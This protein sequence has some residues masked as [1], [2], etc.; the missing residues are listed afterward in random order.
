MWCA[1]YCRGDDLHVKQKFTEIAP[2]IQ[3]LN[4]FYDCV[5]HANFGSRIFKC[6]FL[7]FFKVALDEFSYLTPHLTLYCPY[8]YSFP[9]GIAL[10]KTRLTSP[11]GQQRDILFPSSANI[12]NIKQWTYSIYGL[13]VEQG[14]QRK[15]FY[16]QL[17]LSIV[18][19]SLLTNF[20]NIG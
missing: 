2:L 9:I 1:M 6:V 5:T 12:I 17:L 11:L 8:L 18:Y 7:S 10:F 14:I 15:Q 20:L 3:K 16:M 13:Q 19:L 4:H